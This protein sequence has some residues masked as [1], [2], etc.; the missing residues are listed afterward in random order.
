ME[1]K[2]DDHFALERQLIKIP[3]RFSR[4]HFPI[5]SSIPWLRLDQL[6]VRRSR[7]G[8]RVPQC[9]DTGNDSVPAEQEFWRQAERSRKEQSGRERKSQ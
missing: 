8:T 6:L 2:E 5:G 3:I 7:S 9:L 1:R 4:D